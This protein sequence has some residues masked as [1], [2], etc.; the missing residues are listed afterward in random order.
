MFKCGTGSRTAPYKCRRRADEI[1]VMTDEGIR[2]RGTHEELMRADGIYKEL[3]D[4][5]FR[6]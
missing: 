2:E 3:Y 4:Y 5:Q 6:T 1:I